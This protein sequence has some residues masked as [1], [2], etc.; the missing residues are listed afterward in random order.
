[1]PDSPLPVLDAVGASR[2]TTGGEV[3][4]RHASGSALV[5]AVRAGHGDRGAAD[6]V[7]ACVDALL[8][9]GALPHELRALVRAPDSVAEDLVVGLERGCRAHAF[10]WRGARLASA[11]APHVE[12]E[13]VGRVVRPL[14]GPQAGDVL[15][16]CG[17]FS[18][19]DASFALAHRLLRDHGQL[20]APLPGAGFTGRQALLAQRRTCYGP[21]F[22][23]LQ[24]GRVHALISV[25]GG[26]LI[27]SLQRALGVDVAAEVEAGSW[28]LTELHA[29]LRAHA[30]LDDAALAATF[31]LGIGQV[32][33]VSPA[34]EPH[35]AA[36]LEG[37]RERHWRIG[38]VTPGQGVRL[39]G[40]W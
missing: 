16:G 18:L 38:R 20:G 27:G 36:L 30:G 19:N 26:G 23:L 9:V 25:G 1:M 12:V 31:N 39:T 24:E 32:L 33:A 5:F 14:P 37:W 4:H 3:Q 15:Y 34:D 22:P 29:W 40:R 17:T 13:A 8:A 10:A 6:V 28:P 21:I 11:D 7:A 2:S 35:A